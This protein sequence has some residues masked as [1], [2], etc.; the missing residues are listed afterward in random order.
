[1]HG[2]IYINK[3]K[4]Y[5]A[6]ILNMFYN[7]YMVKYYKIANNSTS[8]EARLKIRTDLDFLE[9]LEFMFK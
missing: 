3:L 8:T 7:F 4:V 9:F 2:F 6:W 1:M 5:A